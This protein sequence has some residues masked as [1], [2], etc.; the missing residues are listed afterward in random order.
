MKAARS[1]ELTTTIL[2]TINV[3][4][5]TFQVLIGSLGLP[6]P[7]TSSSEAFGLSNFHCTTDFYE[8]TFEKHCFRC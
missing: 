7:F 6:L 1:L 4:K 5:K 8:C 2:G 3:V